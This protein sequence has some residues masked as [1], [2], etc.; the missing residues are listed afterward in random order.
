MESGGPRNANACEFNVV[1]RE[2][3][4]L[5]HASL[6]SMAWSCRLRPRRCTVHP[7]VDSFTA[8]G[9]IMLMGQAPASSIMVLSANYHFQ[10]WE[11]QNHQPESSVLARMCIHHFKRVVRNVKA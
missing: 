6:R 2:W 11:Q 7:S 5:L 4:G 8:D 1:A 3:K 10:L 9:S